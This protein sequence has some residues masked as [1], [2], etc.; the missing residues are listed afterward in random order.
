MAQR[1]ELTRFLKSA[2]ARINPTDVGLPAGERR[3]ARG[4]RREEIASLSGMSVTWYTWF[5]QGREVQLSAAMLERLSRTLK[6]SAEEREFL[7]ALAQHR[8]PPLSVTRDDVIRPSTQHLMDNLSLPA[9]VITDDWTV[10]GWN[11]LVTR[12]FRDYSS[13]PAED[14]NLL[15]ILVLSER[16]QEDPERYRSMMQRLTA[17]FK[18]DYS[19]TARVEVFDA[20]I[21]E[22][23]ERSETF[24][25]FW[26]E[27]EI[28]AHFEDIHTATVPGI[29][30]I[31]LRHTSYAIEEAP[32][33][34]LMVFAPID[35]ESA[36]RLRSLEA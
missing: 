2:R 35:A 19:R 9:Q 6:L 32:S 22:M 18:W 28:V 25:E 27:S 8:P 17:R 15:K 10:I 20:L 33:Q 7:F 26:D 36:E 16:Y 12:V 1:D 31:T 4:L 14:R 5:E 30:K 13:L 24:R 34:R 11:G 3:R 21:A 23:L 29:G